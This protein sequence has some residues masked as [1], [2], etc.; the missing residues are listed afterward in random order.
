ML[1]ILG[2]K[3]SSLHILCF[4]CTECGNIFN[5]DAELQKHTVDNH[6]G[7]LKVHHLLQH[8]PYPSHSYRSSEMAFLSTNFANF[9]AERVSLQCDK[10]YGFSWKFFTRAVVTDVT[11]WSPKRSLSPVWQGL[12]FFKTNLTRTV[13]HRIYKSGS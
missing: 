8:I 1:A 10:V 12:W 13:F 4:I 3:T 9:R 5:S 7:C 2:A 6:V 11:S